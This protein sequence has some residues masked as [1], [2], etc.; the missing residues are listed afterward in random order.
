MTFIAIF[1]FL[2]IISNDIIF[3]YLC[4]FTFLSQK[5]RFFVVLVDTTAVLKAIVLSVVALSKEVLLSPLFPKLL[6][7]RII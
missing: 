5:S 2:L 4:I 3:I 1:S 7:C 6:I